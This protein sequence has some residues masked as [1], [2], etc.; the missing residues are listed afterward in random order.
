MKS[1]GAF[2]SSHTRLKAA[3]ARWAGGQSRRQCWG[4]SVVPVSQVLQVGEIPITCS[5]VPVGRP[6]LRVS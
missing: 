3:Q 4:D 5:H 1:S 6:W 2:H